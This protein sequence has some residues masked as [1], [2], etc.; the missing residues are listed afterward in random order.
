LQAAHARGD[1]GDGLG[2]LTGLVG[3]GRAPVVQRE[4]VVAV[5][6]IK[7]KHGEFGMQPG[8][9]LPHEISAQAELIDVLGVV[10]AQ[11]CVLDE[12]VAL[13]VA[14]GDPGAEIFGERAAHRATDG[15][16]VERAVTALEFR[17]ETVA[18]FA[19]DDVN[20]SGE[21][22]CT[23]TRTLRT[24]QDLDLIDIEKH[25]SG[26]GVRKLDAV[27]R[28]TDRGKVLGIYELFQVT[29]ATNLDETRTG[30]AAREVHIGR[31]AQR[32]L[33][34]GRTAF[35]DYALIDHARTACV[36]HLLGRAEAG[37]HDDALVGAVR[38]APGNQRKGEAQ[39]EQRAKTR[40]HASLLIAKETR[41]A[42]RRNLNVL[43]GVA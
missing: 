23:A 8:R 39:R 37:P 41:N 21:R 24:A 27:D 29:D 32:L 19:P 6:D 18:G 9:G 22:A 36:A 17:L 11:E 1:G 33:E 42:L 16:A 2:V 35:R 30:T 20:H 7:V 4:N 34:V 40:G 12:T 5:V 10:A 38:L 31:D 28:Q 13:D 3:A 43:G 14:H 15:P 25:C 26:G